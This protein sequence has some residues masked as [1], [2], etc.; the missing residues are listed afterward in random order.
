MIG[1][2]DEGA[3]NR[4]LFAT[5]DRDAEKQWDEQSSQS[6][7]SGEYGPAERG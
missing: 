4:D 2:Q 5:G 3:L 7:E 1:Q 6:I